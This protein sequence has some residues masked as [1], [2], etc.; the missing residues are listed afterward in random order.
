[1]P[2]EKV[3]YIWSSGVKKVNWLI[4]SSWNCRIKLIIFLKIELF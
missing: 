4:F 3:E 1:M 2:E